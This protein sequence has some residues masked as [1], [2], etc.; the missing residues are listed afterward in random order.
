M[1]MD[2]NRRQILGGGVIILLA[3]VF[4]IY[5]YAGAVPPGG[6]QEKGIDMKP[7]HMP[8]FHMSPCAI[9]QDLEM[10]EGLGL[11]RE[12]IKALR[13]ADLS[14]REKHLE[15]KARLER[16]HFEM[17]KAFSEETLK[18]AT[19]LEMAKRIAEMEG[20]LSIQFIESLLARETILTSDQRKKRNMFEWSRH[21][22]HEMQKP[23]PPWPHQ[24]EPPRRY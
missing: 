1:S 3:L 20:E 24:K 13:D 10:V 23:Q 5:T 15:L 2:L 8:S 17:E 18:E 9:W 4:L 19:V 7:H 11:T 22:G 6:R 21:A 12:Q 14:F 16:F